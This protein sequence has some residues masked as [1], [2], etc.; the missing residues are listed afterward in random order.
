M[1]TALKKPVGYLGRKAV[2]ETPFKTSSSQAIRMEV[3]ELDLP[4]PSLNSIFCL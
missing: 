1:H 3:T 4:T 2:S